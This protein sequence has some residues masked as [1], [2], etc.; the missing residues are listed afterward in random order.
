MKL[1]DVHCHLESQRYQKIMDKVINGAKERGIISIITSSVYLNTAETV[2][3]L[4]NKYKNYIFPTLGFAPSEV[5][6]RPKTFEPFLKFAREKTDS[7]IALGEIGLDYY[8]V[9]D[10]EGQKLQE[11][12]F[13]KL[14][15]L[16][17]EIKK[18]I[19]IHCRDAEKRTIELIEQYYKG[20]KVHMHCFS[21]PVE[22]IERG[23]K[24]GWYF[25]V[26]TSVVNRNYHKN[27]A[28][29]VPLERMF[30]ETDG[31]Y[32]SPIKKVRMN[33]PKYISISAE[34]IA[35][36]KGV[37]VEEVAEKTTQNAL[38]FFGINPT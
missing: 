30:L 16:A 2:L 18:P 14:I 26:P 33:E 3:E 36:M 34:Y 19:I 24:N 1:I 28:K 31:P 5:V 10:K 17:N 4:A 9:K 6:K 8:W 35:D 15:E 32:L 27:L 29:A 11:E 21:G 12:C 7:Y 38:D 13:L 37:S 22:L 20:D 23:L 25:S